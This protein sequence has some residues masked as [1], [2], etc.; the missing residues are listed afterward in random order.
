VA[1]RQAQDASRTSCSRSARSGIAGQ[2]DS[3]RRTKKRPAA[4][5]NGRRLDGEWQFLVV[6]DWHVVHTLARRNYAHDQSDGGNRLNVTP[7]AASGSRCYTRTC[8]HYTQPKILIIRS[9]A[10]EIFGHC[11]SRAA[12]RC[13]ARSWR[14]WKFPGLFLGG[15]FHDRPGKKKKSRKSLFFSY[16]D[17]ALSTAALA[18][19]RP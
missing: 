2:R 17:A 1:L 16:S 11:E 3:R 8:V 18:S 4:E 6:K 19:T 15:G 12:S 9:N 13:R 5:C 14:A 7:K 10:S